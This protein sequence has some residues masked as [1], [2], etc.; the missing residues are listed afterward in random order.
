LFQFRIHYGALY[1]EVYAVSPRLD[2]EKLS[3]FL[4]TQ[5]E[6]NVK[7]YQRYGFRVLERGAIP[8]TE[9]PHWAMLRESEQP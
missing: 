8:D 1:G 3:C 6:K 2:K 4:Q 7:I 9:I 5:S